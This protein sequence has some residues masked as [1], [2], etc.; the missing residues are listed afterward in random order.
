MTTLTFNGL[1]NY[2]VVKLVVIAVEYLKALE[3]RDT[4]I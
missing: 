1:T 3:Y 2:F 4:L